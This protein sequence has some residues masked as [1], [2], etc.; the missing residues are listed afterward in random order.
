MNS[1]KIASIRQNAQGRH[2]LNSA[3]LSALYLALLCQT[4][5]S[6]MPAFGKTL[7]GQ[8]TT[9]EEAPLAPLAPTVVD[10]NNFIGVWKVEIPKIRRKPT[11]TITSISDKQVQGT[12]KGLLGTFP[13]W[14]DYQAET[15]EVRMFVDFSR[16]KLARLTRKSEKAIAHM[17]GKVNLVERTISG[18]ASLPEFSSRVFAFNGKKASS[19]GRTN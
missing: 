2:A 12:Y 14:G 8:V 10:L 7:Q 17:T 4:A 19:E 18:S 11:V 15:G 5:N 16:S 13:L 1:S 6:A 9:I 3:A